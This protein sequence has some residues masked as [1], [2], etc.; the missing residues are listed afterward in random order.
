MKATVL[1]KKKSSKQIQ[2]KYGEKTKFSL[3]CQGQKGEQWVSVW[4]NADTN[5]WKEGQTVTMEIA[6]REYQG[7]TYY[8]GTVI[9]ADYFEVLGEINN[10]LNDIIAML[11][12]KTVNEELPPPLTDDDIPGDDEEVPF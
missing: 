6:P 3:L 5:G 8:D 10:K 1:I 9:K 4:A 11:S 12:A 2:T 7:K